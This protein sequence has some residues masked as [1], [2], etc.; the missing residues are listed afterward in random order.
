MKDRITITILWHD[1]R[2]PVSFSLKKSFLRKLSLLL[3]F[4]L[5]LLISFKVWAL[6]NY[7]ERWKLLAQKEQL[8]QKVADLEEEWKR[9]GEERR[10]IEEKK[11][12][13]SELEKKLLDIQKYLSERGI[14][15]NLRGAVG[16]G[17]AF[18]PAHLDH[19]EALNLLAEDIYKNLRGLPIGY[20]VLGNIT[21]TYGLRKNPFGRGY[22]FHT[23]IDIETPQDTPV[24]ATADGIVVFADSFGN[25]G[26]TIILKHPTGYST[27]YAH[28]SR[29]E[30]HD[31][32]HVK[33]G[34]I[35]GRVGSTGRSTGTHLHYEIILNNK[36]LDPM[37][38]LVWR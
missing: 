33:A 19:L 24:R 8:T 13:L 30:V 6:W 20:P 17:R 1:H 14:R 5:L 36:A 18:E 2:K 9:L 38:F 27:L 26:R 16:G 4:V 10:K 7:A 3:S 31:G 23:G 35:I 32:Q 21:S 11:H 37:K 29:I 25:Y 12:R 28:L 22:E 34:Q 15:I